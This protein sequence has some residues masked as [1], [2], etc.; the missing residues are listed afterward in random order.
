MLKQTIY[1]TRH[2]NESEKLKSLAVF[3][4][5]T[6]NTHYFNALDLAKYLLQLSGVVLKQKFVSNEEVA[7]KLYVK[8]KEIEY[9][10]KFSFND[11]LD[12]IRSMT[13]LRRYIV[14]DETKAIEDKLPLDA[15]PKKNKAIK[16]A[17]E[18]L[19]ELFDK[20]NLIDEIGIIRY[21]LGNT[22]EF[23]NIDFVNY[24]DFYPL[25]IALI[26]KAAGKEVERV[27][28][29]Q[30]ETIAITSYVKA[31]GQTNEVE[32]ILDYINKN[33]IPFDQ[34]LIAAAETKDYANIFNNYKDLLKIPLTIGTGVI[35]LETKPGKLFSIIND[36]MD[37]LYNA[38]Y[39]K[40]VIFDESFN[41]DELKEALLVP[42]DDFKQINKDLEYPESV[43]LDS[44]L[45]TV[46]DMKISFDKNDNNQKLIEYRKLLNKHRE[47]GFNVENTKRRLLELAFVERLVDEMNGGLPYFINRYAV[48]NSSKDDN[49]LSKILKYLQYHKEY[50]ISYEDTKKAIFAQNVGRESIKEGTLYFTS[51]A[52]AL[53]CLRPY[54]FII[55]L[56]SNNFPGSSKE[57]PMLLDEDYQEFGE[58]KA[59]IR[60]IVRNKESFFL[61]LSEASKNNVSIHLSYAYYNSQ[62]LKGQN[63]SSVIFES[64]QKENGQDKTIEDLN[65]EYKK[66]GQDKYKVVEFFDNDVLP[67]SNIGRAIA[68]NSKINFEPLSNSDTDTPIDLTKVLRKP[69]G[70]SASAVTNYAHCPYLFYLTEVL[71]ME[72]PE[73]IDIYEVI[74]AN[75]YGTLAHYLLETL[76]KKVVTDKKQ[77]G[78]IAG[79]RFDE[80]LIMHRPSNPV[81][82]QL[83]KDKFIEMME[84]AYEM[85]GDTQ[86]LFR[87][88]DITTTH[89][90]SGIKIHG[91]P[92]KVIENPDKTVRVIDYKTGR[93]VRHFSYDIASM[94]QC[95]MYAYIIE[96]TKGRTVTSFEY[97]YLRHNH[98]VYS[99]DN[100]KTMSDH[101]DNLRIILTNLRHSLETGEFLPNPGY[102]EDC[103]YKDICMKGGK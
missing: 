20:E 28:D 30:T 2:I 62:S 92:D 96:H 37:N 31:F 55:G 93:A 41:L 9:F 64:Y 49:A 69:K 100:D 103:Y 42:E 8:I 78:V 40:R 76:D 68:N 11:V 4:H 79:Q 74:A 86:T 29:K 89:I 83:E 61:L 59:S 57:N 15:F 101:Y 58:P 14:K 60:S 34:C 87:E 82:A 77:F 33:N 90:E 99:T 1:L 54:L 88:E 73:D 24:D 50:S 67:V 13:D 95:T 7:A 5:N 80:Y 66:E 6:I 97:W 26:N 48:V 44:I 75:E 18:L 3:G 47:E 27:A 51:V 43:S 21:A 70:F 81:I 98:I 16:E 22:K 36:W 38:D 19:I 39:F 32:N 52:N 45:S 94:I 84:N 56:S 53:S 35:L 23:S 85:E 63:A 10:K 65:D 102:C 72:Q 12:L 91:F 17:Y 71:R 25:H 46:G